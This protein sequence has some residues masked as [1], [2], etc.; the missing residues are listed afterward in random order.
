MYIKSP[1]EKPA[2][3]YGG[4]SIQRKKVRKPA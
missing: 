2:D 3:V 1:Y 4:V